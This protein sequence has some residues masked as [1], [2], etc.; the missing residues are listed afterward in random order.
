MAGYVLSDQPLQRELTL[1]QIQHPSWIGWLEI[2]IV[3][4]ILNSM[5]FLFFGYGPG[6]AF[7][8]TMTFISMFIWDKLGQRFIFWVV[9]KSFD[10]GNNWFLKQFIKMLGLSIPVSPYV[11]GFIPDL[12]MR[13]GRELFSVFRERYLDLLSACFGIVLFTLIVIQG[14]TKLSPEQVFVYFL[15]SILVSPILVF[16]II[17]LIWTIQDAGVKLVDENRTITNLS[18]QVRQGFLNRFLGYAGLLATISF[19]YANGEEIFSSIDLVVTSSA[20]IAL[21]VAFFIIMLILMIGGVALLTSAFYLQ[22]YH[23][24]LVNKFRQWL[25]KEK[26]LPIGITI[27]RQANLQEEQAF[28]EEATLMDMLISE[29][30]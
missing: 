18:D 28:L 4:M 25:V 29:D 27:V 16:W 19:L 14:F 30:K 10:S 13:K 8:M 26:N 9:S 11:E 17:P 15:L 5:I 12:K 23:P 20:E 22:F 6:I 21:T 2:I 24:T 3:S 1:F 7:V